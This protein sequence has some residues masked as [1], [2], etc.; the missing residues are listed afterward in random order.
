MER[1]ARHFQDELEVLSSR[2]LEMGGLAEERV[3]RSVHGLAERDLDEIHSVLVG[4]EPINRLHIEID[5]R[6]FRLLALHQPM[7]ADLRAMDAG[8]LA[9]IRGDEM[10]LDE[11]EWGLMLE[12]YQPG[13]D[14]AFY[15]FVCLHCG[16]VRFSWDCS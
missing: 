2:L 6:C 14:P 16:S 12:K 1:G 7:A 5:D 10:G 9:T 13:G 8:Q 15:K 11:K 4:D 3:R